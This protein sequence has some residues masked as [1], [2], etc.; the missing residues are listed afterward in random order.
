MQHNRI[1]LDENDIV[2]ETNYIFQIDLSLGSK[3]QL[4]NER[5]KKEH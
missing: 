1:S 2:S 5:E 4:W 3:M